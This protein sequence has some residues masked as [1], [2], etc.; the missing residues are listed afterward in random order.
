MRAPRRGFLGALGALVAAPAAAQAGDPDCVYDLMDP[1][2][3]AA[4]LGALRNHRAGVGPGPR[5]AVVIHG[6]AITLFA[7]ADPHADIARDYFERVKAGA[8]FFACV[9]TLAGLGWKLDDLLPGFEL[10]ERGG[11]VKLAQLQAGGWAYLR[12]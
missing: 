2:K 3:A 12:P 5:L 8:T 6:P 10:A 4:V 9:N 7:R 11:V 1:P